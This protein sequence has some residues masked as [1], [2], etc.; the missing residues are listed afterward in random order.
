LQLAQV[1]VDNGRP[2]QIEMG[3]WGERVWFYMLVSLHSYRHKY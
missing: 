1:M 3:Q 2:T